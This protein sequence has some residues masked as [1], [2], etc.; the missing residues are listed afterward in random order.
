MRQY[1]EVLRI[2]PGHGKAYNNIGVILSKKGRMTEAISY[3]SKAL[4]IDPSF[5][6]AYNNLNVTKERQ[7]RLAEA[8]EHEK[9]DL[10]SK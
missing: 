1:R 5:A 9:S 10:T 7:R 4:K 6:D 3:F 2:D 8:G